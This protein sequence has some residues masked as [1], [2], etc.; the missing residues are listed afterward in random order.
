[1]VAIYHHTVLIQTV[2]KKNLK[3]I[4]LVFCTEAF[5][6]FWFIHKT[7]YLSY[8]FVGQCFK[9]VKDKKNKLSNGLFC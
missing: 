1:M 6:Y 5:R 3:N 8:V 2:K 4:N 9:T 7:S